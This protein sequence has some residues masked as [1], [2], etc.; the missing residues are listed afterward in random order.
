MPVPAAAGTV[1]TPGGAVA[2]VVPDA[3]TEPDDDEE[4]EVDAPEEEGFAEVGAG[5]A[6]GGA[7]GACRWAK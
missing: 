1:V 6:G 2:E 3:A 5:G 7:G 4:P